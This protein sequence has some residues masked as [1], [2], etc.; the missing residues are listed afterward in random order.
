[1]EHTLVRLPVRGSE[2]FTT[3]DSVHRGKRQPRNTRPAIALTSLQQQALEGLA[4]FHHATADLLLRY[5]RLSPNSLRHLQKQLHTLHPEIDAD[6]H[7]EFVIPPKPR[8]S[9]FGSAPYVYTYGKLGFQYL[10]ERRLISGRYRV[11]EAGVNKAFPLQHRLAVNEFL[12]KA[13]L[14]ADDVPDVRLLTHRHE[15]YWKGKALKVKLPGHRRR[16]GL[17][18]DLLVAFETLTPV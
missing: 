11:P 14:L 1:M 16:A 4:V 15:K 7:I 10:K 2:I 9:R 8:E 6:R 17:S 3:S 12:L 5:A 18:P 13:L